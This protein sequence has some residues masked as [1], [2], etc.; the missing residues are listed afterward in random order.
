MQ[1]RD[2]V[3]RALLKPSTTLNL[4]TYVRWSIYQKKECTNIVCHCQ[5][6]TKQTKV[7]IYDHWS[8]ISSKYKVFTWME[9][10][11]KYCN[12]RYICNSSLLLFTSFLVKKTTFIEVFW[13][14]FWDKKVFTISLLNRGYLGKRKF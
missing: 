11:D 7:H 1:L 10:I 3:G 13:L 2:W 6:W 12:R 4:R 9:A 5:S 8:D 14:L